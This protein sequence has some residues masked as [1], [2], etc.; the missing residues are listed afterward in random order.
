M[1]KKVKTAVVGCGMIS[2]IYLKNLRSM[3]S[4]IELAGCS[5]RSMEKVEQKAAQYGI[6]AMTIEEIMADDSIELVINLT[7]PTAHYA[8]TKELL[9]SEKHVY[10]EKVLA[11]ELDQ[12]EDL[13]QT[14]KRK[15]LYLGAAP[16]TFLGSAAQTARFILDSGIIGEPTGF[17]AVLNRDNRVGA[18]FIPYLA[19]AGGGIG[20]DVGIYYISVLNFILGPARHVSGMMKTRNPK[21]THFLPSKE[22]YCNTYE[23]KCENQMAGNIEYS[24]GAVGTVLFNSESIMN[25]YPEL[26]IY[27]TQGIMYLSDPDAFG[28]NVRVLQRGQQEMIN[29]PSNYGFSDNSRGVG[30]ADLAWAIRQGREPRASKE[31]AYHSLEILHGIAGSS[32]SGKVYEMKSGFIQP[33]PLPQGYQK[34]THFG[35]FEADEEAAL[36][37]LR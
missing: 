6:K 22:D 5:S 24:N 33:A 31:M 2:D 11:L 28:G 15:Q 37:Y 19:E 13:I 35:H 23:M 7:T 32:K 8:V 20:F 12:A 16:D 14:A 34:Q 9:E 30:A 3:F 27:G 25:P 10:T 36:A 21:R 29:F 4:I 1:L 26:A 18:E 17:T